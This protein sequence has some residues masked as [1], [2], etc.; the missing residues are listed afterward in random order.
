MGNT[1][2]THQWARPGFDE[3]LL[4][5]VMASVD[6]EKQA[7]SIGARYFRVVPIGAKPLAREVECLSDSMGKS[8][9]DCLLC[10]GGTKGKSVYITAHGKGAKNYNPELIAIG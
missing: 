8:C 4:N 9:A 3:K 6:T 1:G 10:D 2:Y 7:K 5:Y